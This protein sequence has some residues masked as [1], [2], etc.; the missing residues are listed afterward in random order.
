MKNNEHHSM[1][2]GLDLLLDS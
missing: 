1:N 2:Q